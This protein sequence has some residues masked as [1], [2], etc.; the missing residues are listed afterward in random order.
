MA[1]PRDYVDA[2]LV[3]VDG[4]LVITPTEFVEPMTRESVR[5]VIESV[6]TA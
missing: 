5:D 6:R 4:V 1:A 2:Q 3:E